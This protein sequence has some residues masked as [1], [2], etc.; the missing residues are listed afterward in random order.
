VNKTICFFM[1]G[2]YR[3][4]M[5]AKNAAGGAERQIWLL[6]QALASRGLDV[7]CCDFQTPEFAPQYINGI[8]FFHAGQ[9][10]YLTA[11]LFCQNHLKFDICYFRGANHSL[12]PA[13]MYLKTKNID[14]IYGI[15]F[16]DDCTPYR[17]LAHRRY[18][19]PAY[20]LGFSQSR[21]IFL[22]HAGQLRLLSRRLRRKAFLVPSIAGVGGPRR[23]SAKDYIAWVG[24]LRRPKRPDRLIALAKFCPELRFVVAGG[25]T[26]HRTPPGYGEEIQSQLRGL[27]NVDYRDLVSPDEAEG[28]IAGASVLLST[29]DRE[30][31]PNV[32]LQA[33]CHQVPVASWE[34][35]P[36]GVISHHNLGIVTP[37]LNKMAGQLRELVCRKDK[38]L[39]AGTRG[40]VYVAQNHSSAAAAA[41]FIEGLP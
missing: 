30:G 27:P 7:V 17:A 13:V 21:R 18:F 20:A 31:F 33:W 41:A 32:F 6:A 15:A 16:D 35:D 10:H 34:V 8:R 24:M 26:L 22:Q 5:K 40:A 12:G 2:I 25:I 38:N 4:A 11:L 39:E 37:D 9:R 36:A 29:S 23:R 14:S 1:R 3:V 28:I 19:W